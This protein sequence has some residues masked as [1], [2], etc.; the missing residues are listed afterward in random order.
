MR[1]RRYLHTIEK[2]QKAMIF[3]HK[4]YGSKD[5]ETGL[6]N[7]HTIL[8]NLTLIRSFVRKYHIEASFALI[9]IVKNDLYQK[10]YG[11]GFIDHVVRKIHYAT[12]GIIRES[13]MMG[14]LGHG[15]IALLLFDCYSVH[16]S[17]ILK[18]IEQA[19]KT[20][21]ISIIDGIADLDS[22]AS[23][24]Q[25]TPETNIGQMMYHCRA[26]IEQNENIPLTATFK[27]S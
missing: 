6:P 27:A 12:K 24:Q 2:L 1:D 25:I 17:S 14:Y 22:H 9:R 8:D 10:K 21:D 7:A 4:H 20:I 11:P 16:A 19:I 13:D 18:R 26:I 23:F 15:Y 3:N 5:I